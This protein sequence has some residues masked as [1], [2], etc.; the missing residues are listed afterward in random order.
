MTLSSLSHLRRHRLAI[1]LVGALA[2]GA[3]LT[4][5]AGGRDAVHAAPATAT[6]AAP[7]LTVDTVAPRTQT[8]ERAVSASG[9]VAAR[10]ELIVGSDAAGVRL[11]EVLVDVGAV[12]QRGQLLARGDDAQLLAQLAQ[13]DATIKQARAERVQADA[14]LER[15]E[16]VEDSG[17]YSVEALQTRRTAALQ[18]AA[19]L[20]LAEAQRRELEVRIAHTR[21]VAPA[22][23]VVA[24]RSA[25]VG[26]VMQS[27]Q[28]LFRVIRDGEI[29]WQAELPEHALARVR[30][31]AAV[32][33]MVDGGGAVDASVR[34]VA[35]TIDAKNRNGIVYVALPKD[36]PLKPGAHARGEIVVASA[37][38]QTLPESVVLT[39]DGQPFVY[40]VDA[41]GVAHLQRIDTGERQRGVVEVTAGLAAGSRVVATGA[42]FVKDGEPVRV[43]PAAIRQAATSEGASS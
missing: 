33:V 40:V 14:N 24:K 38:V 32:K 39:R 28:E 8:L 18:A 13:Q 36:A 34:L 17:L 19:K 30:A 3:A 15:A 10:D 1:A 31:G 7:A 6:V 16:R 37:A 21:I 25:T 41:Q 43:A 29:E 4:F 11:V 5:A 22:A 35:P 20:E 2:G 9:S 23:G 26:A 42:G 27:G 12:V